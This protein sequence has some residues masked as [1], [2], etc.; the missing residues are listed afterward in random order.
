MFEYLMM[1]I[2][3]TANICFITDD[4]ECGVNY[5][6]IEIYYL[7]AVGILKYEHKVTIILRYTIYVNTSHNL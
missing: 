6:S 1:Y 5:V 3:D 2:L 7:L 4:M